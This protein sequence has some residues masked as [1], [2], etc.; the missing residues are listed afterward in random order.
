MRIPASLQ[1]LGSSSE[2]DGPTRTSEMER[3]SSERDVG[4]VSGGSGE[5]SSGWRAWLTD[6]TVWGLLAYAL[7]RFTVDSFYRQFGVSSSDVGLGYADL[8]SAAGFVILF[9]V[10]AS[11]VFMLVIRLAMVP[12]QHVFDWLM[13]ERRRVSMGR[14][15]VVLVMSAIA[16]AAAIVVAVTTDGA[17]LAFFAVGVIASLVSRAVHSVTEWISTRQSYAQVARLTLALNAMP[18]EAFDDW[19]RRLTAR[20]TWTENDTGQVRTPPIDLVHLSEGS[21]ASRVAAAAHVTISDGLPWPPVTSKVPLRDG[22]VAPVQGGTTTPRG[23][24]ASW[25]RQN[26]GLLIAAIIFVIIAIAGNRFGERLAS[27]VK[28]GGASSPSIFGIQLQ[29]MSAEPVAVASDVQTTAEAVDQDCLLRLG[30]S[31]GQTVLYDVDNETEL[32]VGSGSVIITSRDALPTAC[33]QP[34]QP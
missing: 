34:T 21:R 24:L 11:A 22:S 25:V 3:L 15:G 7:C 28:S 32:L 1:R 26:R 33:T 30:E 29:V 10:F 5:G 31:G 6:L 16:G 12:L 2:T 4:F 20:Y 8:V 19:T 27:D 13:D 14:A 18:A 9:V 17:P 23:D